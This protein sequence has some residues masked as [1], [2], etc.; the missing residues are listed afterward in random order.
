MI[1]NAREAHLAEVISLERAWQL[2]NAGSLSHVTVISVA[3]RNDCEC[4]GN[5]DG[6]ICMNSDHMDIRVA[7]IKGLKGTIDTLRAGDLYS[8]PTSGEILAGMQEMRDAEHEFSD[9][10]RVVGVA[11]DVEGDTIA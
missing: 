8:V 9:T 4:G 7:M 5:R 6:L 2:W 3:K 1:D 11:D 10:V